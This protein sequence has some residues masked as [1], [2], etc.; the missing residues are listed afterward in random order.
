MKEHKLQVRRAFLVY[1]K[2][3]ANVF[4]VDSY[5]LNRIGLKHLTKR[6][7][8]GSFD[9]AVIFVEGLAAAGTGVKTAACG[10]IGDISGAHWTDDLKN[11]PFFDDF[12]ILDRN[13]TGFT[14]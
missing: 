14:D 3:I 2:E 7:Y 12:V 9:G 5:N 10:M 8:Q 11:Q 1:Q 4:Q 13:N 6:L